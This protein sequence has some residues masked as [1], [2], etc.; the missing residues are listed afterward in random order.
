MKFNNFLRILAD[1]AGNL[2]NID[3]LASSAGI[4]RETVYDYLILLEGT[5]IVRRLNPFFR[6][7]KNELTKMPK[8]YFE[9]NG[10][11]NYLQY[12]DIG[13]PG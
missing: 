9:D 1:Q 13:E 5:Y 4:S 10:V 7:L 11:F 2:L 12:N 6:N 8:I 3:N